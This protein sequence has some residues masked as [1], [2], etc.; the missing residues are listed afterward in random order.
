MMVVTVM[1]AGVEMTAACSKTVPTPATITAIASMVCVRVIKDGKG[2]LATSVFVIHPTVM[3]MELAPETITWMPTVS[4][5]IRTW[6]NSAKMFL[7]L[8]TVQIMVNAQIFSVT[9]NLVS[10]EISVK[11]LRVLKNVPVMGCVI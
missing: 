6:E 10:P 9:V 7:A 4:V 3:D 5:T 8:P 2:P 1:K 11:M